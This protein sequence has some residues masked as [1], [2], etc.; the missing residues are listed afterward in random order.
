MVIQ[1]RGRLGFRKESGRANQ[2]GLSNCDIYYFF[3]LVNNRREIA[4]HNQS[5]TK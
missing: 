3:F 5:I 1:I 4:L 2:E